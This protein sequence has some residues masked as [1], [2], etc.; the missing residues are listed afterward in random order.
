M[1]FTEEEFN[2]RYKS[3]NKFCIGLG[4]TYSIITL[5]MAFC[6]CAILS[7][8]F[9][10]Y[11]FVLTSLTV[12]V[13]LAASIRLIIVGR[14][15]SALDYVSGEYHIP[16]KAAFIIFIVIFTWV[17]V[18][19]A[20]ISIAFAS[21]GDED[22]VFG[23]FIFTVM[24]VMVYFN[25]VF[26]ENIRFAMVIKH[27]LDIIYVTYK[28]EVKHGFLPHPAEDYVQRV[29]GFGESKPLNF[30]HGVNNNQGA[31]DVMRTMSFKGAQDE[32]YDSAS[33]WDDDLEEIRAIESV[34]VMKIVGY[35]CLLS[36]IVVIALRFYGVIDIKSSVLVLIFAPLPLVLYPLI[37]PKFVSWVKP[38]ELTDS[39]AKQ[40]YVQTHYNMSAIPAV[41]IGTSCLFLLLMY[42]YRM[43]IV[44]GIKTIVYIWAAVALIFGVICAIRTKVSWRN[45]GFFFSVWTF[46]AFWAAFSVYGLCY[47]GSAPAIHEP[48]TFVSKEKVDDDPLSSYVTV[49]LQDGTHF[50]CLVLDDL[51]EKAENV[52]LVVCRNVN[53]NEKVYHS[54]TN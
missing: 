14:T 31:K 6:G 52:E 16:S 10:V 18:F 46:F 3:K 23:P 35:I 33:E 9:T 17:I 51:Y 36:Q 8:T 37:L 39:I 22:P 1:H 54:L 40:E 43:P 13:L 26:A 25:V 7:D 47:Y 32:P 19:E 42:F 4:I 20:F 30:G 12:I 28:N 2:K 24:C 27:G 44:K 34:R 49:E 29:V 15:K 45:R 48:C 11:G 5:I 41:V 38:K 21:F 50:E 53:V